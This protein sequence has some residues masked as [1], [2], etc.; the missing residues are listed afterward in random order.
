M[1]SSCISPKWQNAHFVCYIFSLFVFHFQV[2]IV[3]PLL[4]NASV[5]VLMTDYNDCLVQVT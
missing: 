2:D 3:S 4:L 5:L 1:L